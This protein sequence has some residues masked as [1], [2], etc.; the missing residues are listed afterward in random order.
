VQLRWNYG[1]NSVSD[2]AQLAIKVFGIEMVYIPEG[3]FYVGSGGTES[4]AFYTYPEATTP[5]FIASEA[6]IDVGTSTGNLY[7]GN[8][9]GTSGDQ[10][11]PVSVLFP[12]GFNAFYA[13]KYEISQKGYVDFLNTLTRTQQ[14]NKVHTNITGTNV[15]N[16]FVMSSTS[17]PAD[18]NGIR[19]RS[20]VPPAPAPVEFFCDLNNNAIPN[21][22]GDGLGIACN[23][24]DFGDVMS[25]LD[26]AGLRLM[27]EFEFE[28][29]GRGSVSPVP[30][31]YAWGSHV[32]N[33]NSGI[34]NSGQPNEAPPEYYANTTGNGPLRNGAFAR[35]DSDR[36]KAGAGYYG[37]M[38]LS[39]NLYERG[40]SIGTFQGRLFTGVH[41]N[42]TL[43]TNGEA[44]VENWPSHVTADGALNRGGCYADFNIEEERLSDRR[45]ASVSLTWENA[46][47][48]GRGCRTA[49]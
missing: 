36:E 43:L 15:S 41:G 6:P 48:G 16:V 30:N 10:T 38:D 34:L 24:I 35:A 12:K 49:Q 31:E 46:A 42:G 9:S 22:N 20:T 5:Y 26:W 7:Y 11:G 18:R 32:I 23:Y 45:F 29:C 47:H 14:S 27:T 1:A 19:C 17:F 21:E 8:P 44:D 25:Y 3:G 39:G 2:N 33:L 37:C 13:M 4:G 40:V 28:K